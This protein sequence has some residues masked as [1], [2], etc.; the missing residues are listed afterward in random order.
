VGTGR[1]AERGVLFR[2]GSALQRLAEVRRIAFDKTGTLTEGK[3]ELTEFVVATGVDRAEALRLLVA[4]EAQSEHPI[5]R[6]VN[7]YACER[8]IAVPPASGVTAEVG[9][10]VSGTVD[11][12]MIRVGGRAS[13]SESGVDL[14][15]LS[16][17]VAE[18]EA[19]SLTTLMVAADGRLIAAFAI[20]DRLRDDAK[21]TIDGLHSLGLSTLM[22]TGD[23]RAPG[24][25]VQRELGIHAVI[26]EATPRQKHE[27]LTASRGTAGA[28]AFVGDGI[29]DAAALGGAEIGIA[30]GTGTDIAIESADLVLVSA[31]L[32][33]VPEAIRLARATLRNI[34]QNLV[35]AFGYNILLIPL[36]AGLFQP[37]LGLSLSPAFAAGAMAL[38]S[39]FVITNALR[40]R[41]FDPTG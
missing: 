17:E 27:A 11:G 31:R 23:A 19:Q 41:R 10:G 3:P 29:N 24:E 1:A 5:A 6:A 20:A 30:L 38:S 21:S 15:P 18:L 32:S 26:A 40:L 2:D 12:Q 13:M 37:A 22:I 9:R 39:L 36:A 7:A 4:I 35:W 25:R 34:R 16:H 33:A 28:T 14:A 8:G